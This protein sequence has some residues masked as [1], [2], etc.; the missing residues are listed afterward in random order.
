MKIKIAHSAPF[1]GAPKITVPS[2]YGASPDK[3][4]IWRISVLGERPMRITAEGLPAGLTLEGNTVTGKTAAG[5]YSVTLTAE[6][7]HGT[8]TKTVKMMIK[9]GG[10]GQTPLLGFC[11]WNAFDRNVTQ[12]DVEAT[13]DTLISSGLAEY[14]YSYVNIDSGWQ[15]EQTEDDGTIMPNPKFPDMKALTD[16]LHAMGLKCGIYSTPMLNAFGCPKEYKSIP[17]CTRGET[18]PF[19]ALIMGGVGTEHCE[20]VNARRWAEW[21]FDYLKY[22]WTPSEPFNTEPMRKALE[23]TDRDFMMCVT[24]SAGIDFS[25]YWNTYINSWRDNHDTND[26]Y[27]SVL[28]RFDSIDKW[29]GNTRRGH[30]YDLDMLAVGP[31]AMNGGVSGL[32]ENEEQMAYTVNAF[33]PSPIQLS[34]HLDKISDFERDLFSN[35]EIIA[36]NQDAL[37]DYP[38]LTHIFNNAEQNVKVY[39]RK[40]EDGGKAYAIFNFG[41]TSACHPIH[42]DGYYH[43]RDVWSKQSRG[44]N[45][46]FTYNIPEHSAAVFR[47]TPVSE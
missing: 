29:R 19:G 25:A 5:E 22:D 18:D 7:A 41:E 31:M 46:A 8:D 9:P 39:E 2:V 37:A 27:R 21:G 6:N 20:A 14:G 43:I 42:L 13:A 35:E 16:K 17:G 10:L 34:C 32:T 24:A 4:V 11:T 15:H 3:P 28:S 40:L 36:I 30:F 12:A 23:D 45:C 47:I 38:L 1:E 44:I 26:S 33:F